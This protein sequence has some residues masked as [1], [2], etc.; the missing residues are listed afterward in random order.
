MM[1]LIND[2]T[3]IFLVHKD[4]VKLNQF[5]E[6]NFARWKGKVKFHL[7]IHKVYYVQH[8]SLYPL[9]PPTLDEPNNLKDEHKKLKKDK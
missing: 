3:V 7:T 9:P 5:D 2:S 8:S 4:V 6:T 1:A